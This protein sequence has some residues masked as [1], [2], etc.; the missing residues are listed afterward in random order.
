MNILSFFHPKPPASPALCFVFK[1]DCRRNHH[2]LPPLKQHKTIRSGT[3][4][5]SIRSRRYYHTSKQITSIFANVVETLV[6]TDN[7]CIRVISVISVMRNKF[8]ET[9]HH[10][11]PRGAVKTS[12][13]RS[14][15]LRLYRKSL[16]ADSEKL[17]HIYYNLN[18]KK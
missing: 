12:P 7:G 10:L 5:P 16:T 17:S 18:V 3:T 15:I 14:L 9:R 8:R 6:K 4:D 13:H 11:D 2:L 1:S